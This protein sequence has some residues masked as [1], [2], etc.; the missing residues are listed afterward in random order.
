MTLTESYK[1]LHILSQ[2]YPA[3]YRNMTDEEKT[4]QA[5]FYHEMLAEEETVIVVHALKNYIKKNQYPPTVAGLQ[6]QIDLLKGNED[7][8]NELWNLV[9]KA[10]RNGSYGSV[11]EF[12]KLPVECQRWLG[13]PQQLKE[14]ALCE[15]DKLQ[16]V[17]RGQF[18]KTIG[19]IKQSEQAQRTLPAEVRQAI[20]ESKVKLLGGYE[21]EI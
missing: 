19:Q 3:T 5:E 6:E 14:L 2:A 16:Q 7:T 18:L 15:T 1:L 21:N 9:A 8:D 17:V 12:N 4:G 20:S 10:V 13:N 11:E